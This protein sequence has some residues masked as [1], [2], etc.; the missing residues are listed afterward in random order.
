VS[1]GGKTMS[2][3][4]IAAVFGRKIGLI[5]SEKG[6]ASLYAGEPGIPDFGVIELGDA[7]SVS[8]YRKAINE[9]AAAGYDVLIVDSLSHSWQAALEAVD[10]AGGWIKAGKV[11]SPQLAGLM[12]ALLSYPGHVIC[13]MRSKTEYEI[14]K[15]E[16]TGKATMKKIGLAPQVRGDTE[17]EFTVMI[18]L[19]RSGAFTV[20]KSRCGDALPMDEI[21]DRK[22]LPTHFGRVKTWLDKGAASPVVDALERIAF[23]SD[24]ATL[25]IA[26]A[27]IA[28]KKAEGVLSAEDLAKLQ[29][30]YIAQKTVIAAAA[31][32]DVV[33]E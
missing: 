24:E 15:D 16:K 11:V 14:E 5:D 13:T 10:R 29:A 21:Y 1:G 6:S 28:E 2:A 27:Y 9:F 32:D 17:Y 7:T 19:E 31:Q 8:D 12:K 22:D 18:D 25:K 23:A 33:P 20:S 30:A 4:K 26:G 3:L